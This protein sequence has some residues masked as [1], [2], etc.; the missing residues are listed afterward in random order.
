M[1][2]PQ[3]LPFS[4]ATLADLQEEISDF[5]PGAQQRGTRYFAERR[6][7]PIELAADEISATVRGATGTYRVA[8]YREGLRWDP[9]CTCPVEGPCK[10]SYALALAVLEMADEGRDSGD[11]EEGEAEATRWNEGE[12][13]DESSPSTLVR[14]RAASRDWER[15]HALSVLLVR[16]PVTLSAYVSPFPEILRER[17]PD[18]LCWRLAQEIP[19]RTGG[20]L[21]PALEPFRERPDLVQLQAERARGALSRELHTWIQKQRRRTER[22][23]RLVLRI[24]GPQPDRAV[25]LAEARL[26]SPRMADVPRTP[27]QLIQLRNDLRGGAAT[28]SH[29]QVLLLDW[30]LDLPAGSRAA[31][32]VSSGQLYTLLRLL[33]DSRHLSWSTELNEDLAERAGIREGAPVLFDPTPLRLLPTLVGRDGASVLELRFVWPDGRNRPLHDAVFVLG[34]LSVASTLEPSLAICDGVAW[35]VTEE[36]PRALI[37]RFAEARF[38]PIPAAERGATLGLLSSAFPALRRTMAAHTRRFDAAPAVAMDLRNDD[39]M[40][41]RLFAHTGGPDWTPTT[42]VESAVVFEYSPSLAWQR[43]L[44]APTA[45]AEVRTAD[46]DA[47]A[48]PP[49]DGATAFEIMAPESP[50]ESAD[51]APQLQQNDEAASAATDIWIEEPEPE[52]VAAALGWFERLRDAVTTKVASKEP[53]W[54]DRDTGWWILVNRKRL[55]AMAEAWEDRPEGVGF[56]GTPR[57]RRLFTGRETIQARV[58]VVSSGVDW[59][60]VSADWEAEG[61]RLTDDE[62]AELRAATGRFVKLQSGWVRRE[63]V[64]AHDETAQ[65]LADVGI[66]VGD[67]EQTIGL[68]QLAGARSESLEALE[69]SGADPEAIEAV[70]RIRQHV[71]EFA[72][73]PVIPVPAGLTAD[74]RPYQRQGLDFLAHCASLGAGALLADDMGL[75][76]TVQALAWLLHLRQ[77]EPAAGPSLVVCPASVV[78]NWA[79][80]SE[81]FSPGLRVLLLTSGK[82]RHELRKT[83]ADHDLVVTNYA[84]LRRDIEEWRALPLHA[85]ILDEAQNIK[86]PDAVVTR[87]AR[88]LRARHRLALTGTPLENRALDLWSILSFV[89]PGYLGSRGQFAARYDRGD[90][91]PHLRALLSA[92]LRPILLRRTKAEVA[93]ELPDRIEEQVD[94]EMTRGQ[95]Q[96]YLAELRRGRRLLEEMGREP[97]EVGKNR[98]TILAALMRL[99]QICCHPALVG[100]KPALGSG[101]FETLFELLESLLAE[102]HKVLVFSQ[103]VECL[104]LL[105]EEMRLRDMPF[106]MLTGQTTRRERVVQAFERD[107]HASVFLI[108]LKAGGTGL[109]L[110]S[111]SYVV[112]FDPWWNPAVEAQAIDRSHRIGQTRTVIAYRLLTRGTIEEKIFELQQRKAQLVRDVLGDGGFARTLTRED[113]EYL[114]ASDEDDEAD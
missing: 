95:R 39:W 13:D 113:L 92:R 44:P 60:S 18:I 81:R 64:E 61:R 108:S 82:E 91:P 33:P 94:C 88:D 8:W 65:L 26:T 51:A 14:L 27:P 5:S 111:A 46:A 67:G 79:R 6:V 87:A 112:V 4:G 22:A 49:S 76:K 36:P 45:D 71:A 106:H 104:K 62:L 12:G 100:G 35:V 1:P 10:H 109:N 16:A 30:L 20:W 2:S 75:G 25:L 54:S 50:S 59:L 74:L 24:D 68:W 98:V 107:E 66:A 19:Q 11:P 80:E 43:V 58:R 93:P 37:D 69:R 55:G 15:E 110:T 85:A 70:H 78:H 32:T 72:G 34:G 9:D 28:M 63:I 83:I 97:E 99:R 48:L 31:S 38:L 3:R 23:L 102:G 21:P 17:D 41:I 84:L 114:L 103:F 89:N 53:P 101:K 40:Q 42:P 52:R 96:L 7:G 77:Q 47:S 105:A 57:I 73:L 29:D 56:F 86:N 90:S